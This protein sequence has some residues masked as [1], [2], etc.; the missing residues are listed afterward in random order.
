M[1]PIQPTSLWSYLHFSSWEK[2]FYL[3]HFFYVSWEDALWDI[4]PQ[5]GVTPSIRKHATALVPSFFCPDVVENMANHGLK[6]IY[7]PV[8]EHFQTDPMLFAQW[9]ETHQP[10]VVVILHAVGITN[11]LW[12]HTKVWLPSLPKNCLLIEDSV[13]R[14]VNPANISLAHENHVVIDSLRKVSP[15]PGSNFF[16]MA[17]RFEQSAKNVDQP[18]RTTVLWWWLVFQLCLGISTLIRWNP[19]QRFWNFRAEQTMLIGYDYIGDSSVSNNGW[20]WAKKIARYLDFD[21]IEKSK[22]E[23]VT[24]YNAILVTGIQTNRDTNLTL[25]S[26]PNIPLTDRGLLRGFPIILPLS[27][28][29]KTLDDLRTKGLIVRF[30]LNDCPWSQQRK[31]VYL[32]LGPHLSTNDIR[33]IASTVVES[34]QTMNDNNTDN[35]RKNK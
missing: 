32:P 23:Q 30:E 24:A 2:P 22:Q 7:Y 19:W 21:K 28:A 17:G 5:I 35:F 14:V 25:F 18:Y 29:Q 6:S 12:Q 4:L 1:V 26:I 20:L 31:V 16:A 15:V 3:D 34:C 9:L 11:Q 10:Q 33:K 27:T 13:H 8:D